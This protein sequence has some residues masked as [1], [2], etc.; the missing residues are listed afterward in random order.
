MANNYATPYG[1]IQEGHVNAPSDGVRQALYDQSETQ[2]GPVGA[3]R[4]TEDGRTFRYCKFL[5]AV[6]VGKLCAVDATSQIIADGAAT[7]VRNSAGAAADIASSASP[8][9]LYFLDT[10]KF[11]A[12]NSDH[13]L[14]GGY[15]HICNNGG[16]GYNYRIIDNDYTATTSVMKVN[17]Y[18]PILAN[19]D[20]EAEVAITGNPYLN[21]RVATAGTDD[22]VVGTSIRSMTAGYYGWLQ[23]WGVAT[24]LADGTITAGMMLTLSDG[25]AGAVQEIGGGAVLASESDI[26]FAAITTE[27]PVGF[28]ISAGVDASYMPVFLQLSP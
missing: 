11:T 16:E 23:T 13:V 7:A 17:I 4:V 6:T 27:P 26:E 20:S 9:T 5:A 2:K 1:V 10:D 24:I 3:R 8:T 28:A 21:V 25:V 12:A 22:F 18:D 15:L 14:A 19:I